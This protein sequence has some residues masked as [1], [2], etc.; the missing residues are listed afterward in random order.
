MDKI[1]EKFP[2]IYNHPEYKEINIRLYQNISYRAIAEWLKEKTDCEEDCIS[3]SRIGDYA[4][5]VKERGGFEQLIDPEDLLDKDIT[6]L[7]LDQHA[8]NLMYT[9]L[10]KLE[11]GNFVQAFGMIMKYTRSDNINLNLDMNG[12]IEKKVTHNFLE[13]IKQDRAEYNDLNHD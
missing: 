13:Q 5:Y 3:P 10:H 6:L 7:E 2:S 12:K 1:P 9:K 8:I 11:D 4:R